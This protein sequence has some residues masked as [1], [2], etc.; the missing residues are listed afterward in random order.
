MRKFTQL[1]KFTHSRN[2]VLR[3]GI[4]QPID[5]RQVIQATEFGTPDAVYIGN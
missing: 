1:R 3:S 5:F 4:L 2:Q